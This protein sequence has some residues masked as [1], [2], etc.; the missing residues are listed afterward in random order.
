MQ[1]VSSVS[2]EYVRDGT[3][4]DTSQD[5]VLLDVDLLSE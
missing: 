4:F 2:W 3:H 5:H 1:V